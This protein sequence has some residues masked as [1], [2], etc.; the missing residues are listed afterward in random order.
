LHDALIKYQFSSCSIFNILQVQTPLILYP[1]PEGSFDL[2]ILAMGQ[3]WTQCLMELLPVCLESINDGLR[4]I[5]LTYQRSKTLELGWL[6]PW[7]SLMLFRA[8]SVD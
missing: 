8:L 7:C 3:G 1:F 4:L 5:L 6:S 2:I